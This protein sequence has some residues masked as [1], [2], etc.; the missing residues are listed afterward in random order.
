MTPITFPSDMTID[1]NN[2]N[3][4]NHTVEEQQMTTES[5]LLPGVSSSFLLP[6]DES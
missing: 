5:I 3:K 4:T 1:D 6:N 2:N